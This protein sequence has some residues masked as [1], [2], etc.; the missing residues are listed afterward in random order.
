MDFSVVVPCKNSAET[1]SECLTR[2]CGQTGPSFEV[3]LVDD[4]S[5][6][7]SAA[8]AA[9]FPVQVVRNPRL[10]VSAARNVGA[11][12]A[13]GDWLIFT[14]TDVMWPT[15]VLR[16]LAGIREQEGG[17]G[18]V[19]VQDRTLR[20]GNF[21]SRFK[22]QWMRYTYLQLHG[23][24]PQALFYTSLA[25][26]DR[27]VFLRCGGFDERYRR[28]GIEDTVFGHRLGAS[29]YGVIVR[30]ELAYE[31][32]RRYSFAELLQTDVVRSAA[33]M[34]FQLGRGL[35]RMAG[36]NRTSVP[37]SYMLAVLLTPVGLA[38]GVAGACGVVWGGPAAGVVLVLIALLNRRWIGHLRREEGLG[39]AARGLAFLYLE[40]VLVNIG[41]A[42]GS[43]GLLLRAVIY[44]RN[45]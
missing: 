27:E 12:V 30:R 21:S 41:M 32:A 18:L 24:G 5:T 19:G 38:A 40:L 7:G 3:I 9:R 11:Q 10:G 13:R 2:I 35:R 44:P 37:T 8:L 36:G 31:H 1:L 20:F 6:D 45:H 42:W 25:A 16:T 14:D 23:R 39:L 22:N 28:P 26:I 29:G 43:G 17:E 4:G 33:L 15:D 34:R